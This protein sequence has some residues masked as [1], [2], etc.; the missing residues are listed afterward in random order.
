MFSGVGIRRDQRAL[1]GLHLQ[2][3]RNSSDKFKVDQRPLDALQEHSYAMPELQTAKL[4]QPPSR[5]DTGTPV[6]ERV[7]K[8]VPDPAE[9][10]AALDRERNGPRW[11]C[12]VDA[13]KQTFGSLKGLRTVEL[14]SG[15]AD[16]SVLLAQEGAEVTLVDQSDMALDLA[17]QRFDR[18]GLSATYR[19]GD[20]LDPQDLVQHQFDVS[21]SYGVIEH[22]KNDTRT[23]T[24]QTHHDVI[25][26]GGM[27]VIGVPNAWC[28]QYRAWKAYLE[29][30]GWWPYGME[31][32]YSR[33]ELLSRAAK[34]GLVDL[35]VPCTG[36][37]Q[38][39]G[40]QWGRSIIGRGPDWSQRKSMLDPWFGF[41]LLLLGWRP[42]NV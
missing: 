9:D 4:D 42:S 15:R 21:L 3:E 28:P 17:R 11:G 14:G 1:Q 26:P 38:A 10:D 5:K 16:L 34:T 2:G 13:M 22:F 25:R 31:I 41:S 29:L 20:L 27:V 7:W 35:R 37:W 12:M 18:L 24:I 33:R 6:W 40:D 19:E 36:F 23:K 39:L 32:P 30:R 8:H